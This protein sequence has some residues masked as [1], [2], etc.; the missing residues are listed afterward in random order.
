MPRARQSLVYIGI[1]AQ[2]LAFDRKSGAEMWRTSL[3]V[4]YKSSGTLV[5]VVRDSEGLFASCGGE[6]F[7]LDPKT[8]GLLW[9][10]PL[11]GLGTGLSTV[12]TDLGSGTQ[13][14]VLAE[15]ERQA[16]AAAATTAAAM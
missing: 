2:V 13:L 14:A 5:N 12:A 4:T 6:L 3:P 16:Q 1:K 15:A 8:G 10:Q 9:R 11:K 7:A